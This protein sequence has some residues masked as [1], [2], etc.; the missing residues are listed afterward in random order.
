MAMAVRGKSKHYN[1][2][3]ILRRH[4][5]SS[6]HYSQFPD[7]GIEAIVN[8]LSGMKDSVKERV[9]SQAA[10]VLRSE[11]IESAVIPILSFMD[12]AFER[13]SQ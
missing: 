8:E 3:N 13:I 4:W 6:A 5:F 7:E 9:M 11:H 10:S 12:R 2:D 1:W